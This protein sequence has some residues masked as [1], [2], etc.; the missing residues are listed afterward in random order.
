ME[1]RGRKY[2]EQMGH[3]EKAE[4]F[5]WDIEGFIGKLTL[6]QRT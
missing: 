5:K 1:C 6:E 2:G 4:V 3:G